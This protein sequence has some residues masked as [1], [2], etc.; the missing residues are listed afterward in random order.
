MLG[1]S[2]PQGSE[3]ISYRNTLFR[4][5]ELCWIKAVRLTIPEI[6]VR[7]LAL[8]AGIAW[9]FA[10][11]SA[12]QTYL[13][14]EFLLAGFP[15]LLAWSTAGSLK[16]G[17]S[18]DFEETYEGRS[19]M[20]SS[21]F[22]SWIDGV[23]RK[24]PD[25]LHLSSG[26]YDLLLNPNRVAWI[27]PCWQWKFYPLF[28]IAV[29][30]GYLAVV[31]SELVDFES[32]PVLGEFEVLA[33]PGGSGTIQALC[34]LVILTAIAAFVLSIKRSVEICGTGG[35]QDVFQLSAQDQ[36]AVLGILAGSEV[37]RE[38]TE[39]KV[40]KLEVKKT[41]APVKSVEVEVAK[42]PPPPPPLAPVEEETSEA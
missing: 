40:R 39:A 13:N 15:L 18:G 29:F 28:V 37:R 11:Q 30:A 6:V 33:F 41:P 21:L 7:V 14:V 3:A 16:I 35:V 24:E 10:M 12:K 32:L 20:Q 27:R 26:N 22:R 4:I 23:R 9:F 17:C 5:S 42:D 36:S 8:L 31:R 2:L 34:Y 38:P 1:S 25:W 19:G